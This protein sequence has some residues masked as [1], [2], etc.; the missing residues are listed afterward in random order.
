MLLLSKVLI[1]ALVFNMG[2]LA[3]PMAFAEDVPILKPASLVEVDPKTYQFQRLTAAGLN[4]LK[5]ARDS[6]RNRSR[7]F[8]N[9]LRNLTT[10]HHAGLVA[11]LFKG[12]MFLYGPPGGAKSAFANWLFK[13][14]MEPAYRLQL[15]Q[16]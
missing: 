2:L 12:N 14:E 5:R 6:I 3:S 13:G 10:V 1:L 15:H 7:L 9:E 4:A 8:E 11:R 16:M